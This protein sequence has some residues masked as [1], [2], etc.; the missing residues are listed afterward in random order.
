MEDFPE[1]GTSRGGGWTEGTEYRT[2]PRPTVLNSCSRGQLWR[3]L[4]WPDSPRGGEPRPRVELG[5]RQRRPRE[6]GCGA[7][8]L[9]RIRLE[10]PP[11]A[12]GAG[13]SRPSW[14]AGPAFAFRYEAR[15]LSAEVTKPR[16]L[17]EA[18]G[19]TPIGRATDPLSVL[20]TLCHGLGPPSGPKGLRARRGGAFVPSVFAGPFPSVESELPPP[21]SSRKS[22]AFPRSRKGLEQGS[23]TSL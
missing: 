21:L 20:S 1:L 22:S 13:V 15:G 11:W 4:Q 6:M 14:T 17:V 16:S 19:A 18:R 5:W 12:T 7:Q 10:F 23:E 2:C 9:L 3:G 8:S